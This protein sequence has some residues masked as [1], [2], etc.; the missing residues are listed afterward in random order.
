MSH[1][2]NKTSIKPPDEANPNK[3]NVINLCVV[4]ATATHK[5]TLKP[6]V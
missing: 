5:L 1:G 6:T 4:V 2:E 3:K